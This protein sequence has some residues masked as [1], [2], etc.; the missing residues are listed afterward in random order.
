MYRTVLTASVTYFDAVYPLAEA[1]SGLSRVRSG[2]SP[3]VGFHLLATPID[4]V[5]SSF[6]GW[7][8]ETDASIK[9]RTPEIKPS[10]ACN[11]KLK[12]TAHALWIMCVTDAMS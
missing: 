2:T 5:T 9:H 3:W 7:V 11:G 12:F 8:A 1:M 4:D 6:T 10:K